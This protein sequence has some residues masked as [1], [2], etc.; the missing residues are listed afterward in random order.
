MPFMGG[1][2]A[3]P[4]GGISRQDREAKEVGEPH[5]LQGAPS[6]AAMPAGVTDGFEELGPILCPGLTTGLLREIRE[7]TGVH[8]SPSEDAHR[9]IYAGRWLTPPLGPL[10]FDN[11]FFLI[12]W[13]E[14]EAQQPEA[15]PGEAE[16]GEWVRPEVALDRW[17]RG[18][19]ITAPPILHI[20][21]VLSEDGPERGL[22]RLRQPEEANLGPHRRIEFRPGVLL[23]PLR[24]PTLPPASHTN[25]YVLG[26]GESVLVD[27]GSPFEIEIDRL[28]QALEALTAEGGRRLKAIWLTHHHPDHVGGVEDLRRRF[29]IPVMAHPETADRLRNVGIS[30]D[31]EL[32]DGQ[33][34]QLPGADS[35]PVRVLH[36]PGHAS[37]HLCFLE[38]KHG[39]LIAGDLVAGLGTIVI[40]PPDG[41]MGDYLRSLQRIR[42]LEPTTLFPSHGPVTIDV[43]ARLDGLIEHRGWREQRILEAWSSGSREPAELRAA[44]YDDLPTMAHPLAERQVIAHLEH[45]RETGRLV[46]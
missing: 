31:Q 39:S 42:D 34:I 10:R 41:N 8:L 30:V 21:Q 4:G 6:L 27:P 32:N 36:T 40:D 12:E 35:F 16:S 29:E 28:A 13:P 43:N 23:F 38:E 5:G 25:C 19:V 44:V 3:F 22:G 1:F 7:E 14:S 11:R 26:T 17:H 9:L 46:D 20:L 45:L 24:T 15:T 2:H 18:K 33:R 37:G